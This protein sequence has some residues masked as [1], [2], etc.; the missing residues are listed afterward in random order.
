MLV[1]IALLFYTTH[2]K[3]T[4]DIADNILVRAREVSKAE[5]VPLKVMVEEG[6]KVILDRHSQR[7]VPRVEPVTFKGEGL[8]E[9]FRTASWSEIRDAAYGERV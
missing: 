9:A 3:T 6:L 8:S 7:K 2:M 5:S 4:F 1:I